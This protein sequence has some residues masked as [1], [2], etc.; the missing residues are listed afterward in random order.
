[1]RV[2]IPSATCLVLVF[3]ATI[4]VDAQAKSRDP[5]VNRP[6]VEAKYKDAR[7]LKAKEQVPAGELDFALFKMKGRKWQIANY[8]LPLRGMKGG[9][10]LTGT[11]EYEI[12]EVTEKSASVQFDWKGGDGKS[13][14]KKPALEEVTFTK[15]SAW[16]VAFIQGHNTVSV[17]LPDQTIKVKAGTFA[18][19]LFG[20]INVDGDEP[21][22]VELSWYSK[23]Y[24]GL[25][26]MRESSTGRSELLEFQRDKG[27][28]DDKGA[29]TPRKLEFA[30]K[31]A[32][33]PEAPKEE[34]K[35]PGQGE[36]KQALNWALFES[37]GRK[38]TSMRTSIVAGKPVVTHTLSEIVTASAK[39]CQ[40]WTQAL[41]K[42]KNPIEGAE[43][44][45][46]IEFKAENAYWVTPLATYK[47]VREEK[48]AAAGQD[49]D[50][51]VY[52]DK[53]SM[54]DA[55]TTAWMSK[56]YPGLWIKMTTKGK[57]IDATDELIEFKD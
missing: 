31:A 35:E 15:D 27:D 12:L 21:Q 38:W 8:R 44:T 32:D 54:K 47:K 48:L 26:V 1:M 46:T 33:K 52:E 22:M 2:H 50:C 36:P 10:T 37:R 11:T 18:C 45:L 17:Q 51:I 4:N 20:Q 43:N 41:D 9:P 28:K 3:A 30:G 56:K 24:P 19:Y 6:A 57:H 7:V 40:L 5:E 55:V 49:W 29:E 23:K 39:S 53:T 16:K 13:L 34:V 14:N 42:D 25:Q